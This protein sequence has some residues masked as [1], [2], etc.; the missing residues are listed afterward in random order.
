[1][2][3]LKYCGFTNEQD[4]KFAYSFGIRIF[5][6]IFYTKSPRYV[7]PQQV[8]AMTKGI[9]PFVIK[10][11]VFVNES[12]SVIQETIQT[13]GLSCIQLHG[14]ESPEF[15][16]EFHCPVIK[17]FRIYDE[18]DL[19]CLSDYSVS[20]V[21]L[22]SKVPDQYGGSGQSFDWSLA[23]KASQ[24]TQSPLILSGGIHLHNI[25][26]AIKEVSPYAIDMSSGIEIAPGQKDPDKMRVIATL[27]KHHKD[28]LE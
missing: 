16:Q 24:H 7:T 14:D 10:V 28:C 13:A 6:F 19:T 5:G 26:R 3:H 8:Y 17:A 15:C 4:L 1:M 27:V 12:A 11:G 20:A 22:D 21:L 23:R 25:E 18:Q 9:P 2:M